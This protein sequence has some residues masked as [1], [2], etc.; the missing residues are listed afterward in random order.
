MSTGDLL[1]TA[2]VAATA[3]WA[4]AERTFDKILG[5]LQEIDYEPV[6]VPKAGLDERADFVRSA[7]LS[8]GPSPP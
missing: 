8:A 7:A 1:S 2:Y 6:V 4:E 3:T 5:V